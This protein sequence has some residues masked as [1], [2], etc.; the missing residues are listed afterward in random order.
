[1]DIDSGDVLTHTST[2]KLYRKV[3]HGQEAE[4][5]PSAARLPQGRKLVGDSSPMMPVESLQDKCWECLYCMTD[6]S[7]HCSSCVP[8]SNIQVCIQ[9]VRKHGNA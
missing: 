8:H 7:D 3:P 4:P 1:M 5:M 9:K 6:N 2:I